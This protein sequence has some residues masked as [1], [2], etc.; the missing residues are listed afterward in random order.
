[1]SQ[2]HILN[3]R[4]SKSVLDCVNPEREPDHVASL[5]LRHGFYVTVPDSER[6][7]RTPVSAWALLAFLTFLNVIN[8]IDRQLISSLAVS[9]R[10]E[11][12]LNDLHIALLSGYAFAILYSIVGLFLGVA[13]DHWNRARLIAAGLAVWSAM[14]AL[15]GFAR[16][17]QEMALARIFVGVGEATLTPA[18][19]AM[20][21]DAFPRRQHSIA[22][23]V[24]YL[25]IPI[26]ASTSFLIA[27]VLQPHI[28]WRHCFHLL[29]GLG[30][31]I[32]LAVL[33]VRDPRP[34]IND[35]SKRPDLNLRR[36]AS[37]LAQIPGV[38]AASPALFFTM[39]GGFLL[40][41]SVGTTYLD[42]LWMK[43]DRQIAPEVAARWMSVLFLLG[44]SVGNILGGW[45]GDWLSHRWNVHRLW[46]VIAALLVCTPMT[47]VF[48]TV[49]PDSPWFWISYVFTSMS[50]TV[51]YGPVFSTVQQLSPH[52]LRAMVMAFF[53]LG[54]NLLGVS[55]GA[56]VAALLTG[57]L[58]DR[59]LGLLLTGLVGLLAIPCFLRV[60]RHQKSHTER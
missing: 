16:S 2:E 12:E 10:D 53:L 13:A 52:A 5:V 39:I 44:G 23:G 25:G 60:V 29:G 32:S 14:T 56:T 21:G 50:V 20:L 48:R 35:G 18:A 3:A 22:S 42:M 37:L 26:G 33:A 43:D 4:L 36:V 41:F 54:M 1:L 31:I 51:Y 28:G 17:F 19:L 6:D 47:V 9:I 15:S 45:L 11:L 38:L 55:F 30:V 7:A 27:G 24:Y 49:S 58:H 8:F 40:N 57:L 46:A 59:T 34:Q